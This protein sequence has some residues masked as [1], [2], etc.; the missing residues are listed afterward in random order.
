MKTKKK[1]PTVFYWMS[2]FDGCAWVRCMMPGYYGNM[3]GAFVSQGS[4]RPVR[5]ME[6]ADII[7][8]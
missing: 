2:S 3:S 8:A 5:E 4:L 1:V 6:K 7:V